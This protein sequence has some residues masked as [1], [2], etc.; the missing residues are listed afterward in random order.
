MNRQTLQRSQSAKYRGPS[1]IT[2]NCLNT[3][4]SS[5]LPDA[6][7]SSLRQLFSILDKTNCG[8][9]P[10]NVFKRYF[11]CSSLTS[12]FLNHLE[13][14]SNSNNH[15]ITF[16]SLI[17]VIE[18]SLPL[19]NHL[20]SIRIPKI[21]RPL[22]RSTSFLVVSPIEEKIERQI[23]IIYR[24]SNESEEINSHV[25]NPIYFTKQLQ[26]NNEINFSMIRSLK[27]Y[28]I[29]H[30]LL[31]ETCDTL[32]R[33]KLYL[34]NC[35]FEMKDKQKSYCH[36]L[37]TAETVGIESESMYNRDL[38]ADLFKLANI[39]IQQVNYDVKKSSDRSS[40]NSISSSF[41]GINNQYEK[42]LKA[43]D[44]YIKQL[45]SEKRI[46]LNEIIEMKY[47]PGTIIPIKIS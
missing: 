33:V 46:L 12:D 32:D 41:N 20:S 17:N 38:V 2:N 22:N 21:I 26:R 44:D 23:P 35:L 18:R 14:E 40:S 34:T 8:Y 3:K 43:K 25:S 29:E 1:S 7:I 39:V 24:N 42:Q 10:Y 4:I 28:E 11:D 9:I 13:I 37:T 15:L 27:Q 16:N 5:S 47:Q 30:N 45:E 6:F 19:T 31:V 36:Y